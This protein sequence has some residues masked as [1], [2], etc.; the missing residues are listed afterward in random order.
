MRVIS[1][2][3]KGTKLSTV[4]GLETRPTT[5]RLKETLFNMIN[6]ELNDCIF[7]DLFSGSGAIGIEALSRGAKKCYFIDSS[8]KCVGVIKENLK[9]TKLELNAEIIKID[10]HKFTSTCLHRFDIIFTDA[11][12]YKNHTENIL[13]NILNRKL[14]NKNGFIIV[15]Q[16]AKE[17][18][19]QIEG[20]S[21]F[22]V[23]KNKTTNFIFLR[24]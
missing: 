1:G 24:E 7:L 23:K 19:P 17:D 5:D 15:E 11:P 13:I 8:I 18:L 10:C 12:Y 4:E 16:G 6:S 9:N 3:A 22:K 14:L 21:I 20:L 2:I